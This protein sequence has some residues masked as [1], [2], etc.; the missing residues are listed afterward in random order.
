VN[1]KGEER[2]EDKK[3]L[4][5]NKPPHHHRYAALIGKE[6]DDASNDMVEGHFWLM[7][8]VIRST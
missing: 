4:I 8:G 7:R 6:R 2:K 3:N 1:F 5:D